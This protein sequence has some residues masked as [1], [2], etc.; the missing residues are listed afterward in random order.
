MTEKLLTISQAAAI[1]GIHADTLRRW[2]DRGVV[3]TV[4]LPSGYRRFRPGEIAAL[5]TSMESL[6]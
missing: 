2:S 4:R 1:L 3:P 5:R 6:V